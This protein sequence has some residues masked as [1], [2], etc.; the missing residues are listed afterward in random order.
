MYAIFLALWYIF[1]KWNQE[2]IFLAFPIVLQICYEYRKQNGCTLN[3]FV[4]VF[5]SVRSGKP[6]RVWRGS[7]AYRLI[8]PANTFPPIQLTS[9]CRKTASHSQTKYNSDFHGHISVSGH[10]L[11]QHH[12]KHCIHMWLVRQIFNSECLYIMLWEY[13]SMFQ[14]LEPL[15]VESCTHLPIVGIPGGGHHL[16]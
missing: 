16:V 10:T 1:N 5:H 14:A 13:L 15:P 9:P 8:I 2:S 4:S 6:L 3:V 12:H 11:K 7:M